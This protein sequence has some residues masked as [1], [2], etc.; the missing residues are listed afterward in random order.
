MDSGGDSLVW[1]ALAL[2]AQG[3]EFDAQ[4]LHWKVKYGDTLELSG[5]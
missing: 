3:P 4:H 1:K 2:Q 5:R